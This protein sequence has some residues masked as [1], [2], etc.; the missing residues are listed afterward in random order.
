[1]DSRTNFTSSNAHTA[2]SNSAG[3]P[4]VLQNQ[5]HHFHNGVSELQLLGSGSEATGSFDMIGATRFG[6]YASGA[7]TVQGM[8]P[9]GIEASGSFEITGA[10]VQGTSGTGTFTSVG[11]YSPAVSSSISFICRRE[12]CSRTNSDCI[13]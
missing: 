10:N 7:F 6:Q 5:D 4:G 11:V 1:M 2:A 9:T 3:A 8:V 12:N 13:F